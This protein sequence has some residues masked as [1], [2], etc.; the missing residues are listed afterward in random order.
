MIYDS[1]IFLSLVSIGFMKKASELMINLEG[2][3]NVKKV[4]R[5]MNINEV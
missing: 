2:I 4:V 3:L 5:Q 1:I